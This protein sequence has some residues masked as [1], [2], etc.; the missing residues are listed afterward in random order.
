MGAPISALVAAARLGNDPHSG[1]YS[2]DGSGSDR[3]FYMG[4]I[5]SSSG[6]NSDYGSNDGSDAAQL[7]DLTN[8]GRFNI[9]SLYG[10][11]GGSNPPMW[12]EN[13]YADNSGNGYSNLGG[14]KLER[15]DST[16]T[17]I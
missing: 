6:G 1:G 16:W 17:I 7:H 9:R 2:D 8:L 13:N 14:V 3:D 5:G 11:S 12:Q 10:N 4:S 15:S